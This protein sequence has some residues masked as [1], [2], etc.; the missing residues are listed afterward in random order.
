MINPE[1]Q[2]RTIIADL[3]GSAVPPFMVVGSYILWTSWLNRYYFSGPLWFNAQF[4]P[5]SSVL[6][7]VKISPKKEWWKE[8]SSSSFSMRFIA[9]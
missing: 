7:L 2:E 9:A 3:D 8:I 1:T 6:E 5:L 4:A